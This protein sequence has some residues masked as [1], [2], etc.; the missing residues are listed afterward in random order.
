[1]YYSLCVYRDGVYISPHGR[2][3]GRNVALK[4][5][6]HESDIIGQYTAGSLA[7]TSSIMLALLLSNITNKN[8]LL[9]LWIFATHA[10]Q[11]CIKVCY[12]RYR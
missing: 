9:K 4:F 11:E 7:V 8:H 3:S 5:A 10:S 12:P 6:S 2:I 1:M